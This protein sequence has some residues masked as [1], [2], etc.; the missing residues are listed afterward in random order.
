LESNIGG[1]EEASEYQQ[2]ISSKLM[3]TTHWVR[4]QAQTS[5]AVAHQASEY[6]R[7]QSHHVGSFN[8]KMTT[9]KTQVESAHQLARNI[10]ANVHQQVTTIV[11]AL[12]PA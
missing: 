10:E 12:K 8:S 6:I 1:I 7:E 11:N 2:Q 9:V 3:Q 4:E 5:V